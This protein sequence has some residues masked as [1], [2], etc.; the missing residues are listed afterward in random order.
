MAALNN[1]LVTETMNLFVVNSEGV[2]FETKYKMKCRL[3]TM[4]RVITSILN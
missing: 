1:F 3:S 2:S 4:V